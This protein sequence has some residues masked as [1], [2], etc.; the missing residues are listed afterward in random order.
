MDVGIVFS[1]SGPRY[2]VFQQGDDWLIQPGH[3]TATLQWFR[4]G[5]N[6]RVDHILSDEACSGISGEY[7]LLL[8]WEEST[9][10]FQLTPPPDFPQACRDRSVV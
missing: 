1:R 8:Y 3:G 10:E 5:A 9:Q 4:P 2:S 7:D 6:L